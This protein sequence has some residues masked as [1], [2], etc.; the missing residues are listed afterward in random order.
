M[1]NLEVVGYRCPSC[2]AELKFDIAKQGF[3]CEYC[4]SVFTKKQIE[5]A[6]PD[7]EF[8]PLDTENTDKIEEEAARSEFAEFNSVYNCPGCGASVITSDK[9]TA[10]TFCH[11]C[12][13]PIILTGRLSGEFKPDKIIPFHIA[14]EQAIAGFE[15][16]C[17][18]KWFLPKNFTSEAKLNYINALYVPY[19]L[20][21]VNMDTSV[22]AVCETSTTIGNTRHVKVF[23]CHR[24]AQMKFVKVPADGSKR[25]DD[26]LMSSIEPFS[27]HELTDF[28]MSYL[29]GIDAEKYDMDKN[30]VLPYLRTTLG[31]ESAEAVTESLKRTYKSVRVTSKTAFTQR[32]DWL[33]T[34]LPVWFMNYRYKDK[35]YTFV[36]NGQT[37]KYSGSL[38]LSKLK[39]LLGTI[40]FDVCMSAAFA[41]LLAF[42]ALFND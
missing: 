12:H 41:L 37:G 4:D 1:D 14:K 19:W 15:G 16:L 11:Y 3:S 40:V 24:R 18:S 6:Y 32:I 35:D 25:I 36:M 31:A 42:V 34:L 2:G 22:D 29:S 21:D 7:E 13:S 20:A 26:A 39:L 8:N 5:E 28:S 23:N 33:Y 27:Y 30:A 9:N 17:K 38:P 10:S